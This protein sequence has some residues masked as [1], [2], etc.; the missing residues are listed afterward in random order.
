MKKQI[1][2]KNPYTNNLSVFGEEFEKSQEYKYSITSNIKYYYDLNENKL[3]EHI[4]EK[5][6]NE[7]N[8]NKNQIVDLNGSETF[9]LE[10]LKNYEIHLIEIFEPLINTYYKNVRS[11]GKY[12]LSINNLYYKKFI[13]NSDKQN[14][15]IKNLLKDGYV[16]YKIKNNCPVLLLEK[17]K[18]FILPNKKTIINTGFFENLYWYF[19]ILV[20]K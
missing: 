5:H 4:I 10:R 2:V 19:N 14:N 20:Y 1:L 11:S 7:Q 9:D 6:I 17:N 3:Y 12:D 16:Y 13:I 18:I 15:F 8:S